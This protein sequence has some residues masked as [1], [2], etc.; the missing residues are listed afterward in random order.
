[1]NRRHLLPGMLGL[2]LVVLLLVACG[3]SEA[4]SVTL[5][6]EGYAQ[7]ELISPQG[8]RVLIDV[9]DPS[10]LISPATEED[11]LL[12]THGHSDHFDADFADS[13]PGQQL[14]I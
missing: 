12:T 6:H 11:I 13:F 5:Y 4:T 3:T 14:W 1:M 7:V 2:T 8:T 9:A 10:A